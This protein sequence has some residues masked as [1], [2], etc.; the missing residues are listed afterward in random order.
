MRTR[1]KISWSSLATAPSPTT[2]PIIIEQLLTS[3]RRGHRKQSSKEANGRGFT[4]PSLRLQPTQ[5][6]LSKRKTPLVKAQRMHLFLWTILRIWSH[7][8]QELAAKTKAKKF[9]PPGVYVLQADLLG[10]NE[11]SLAAYLGLPDTR[12]LRELVEP[13][14]NDRL[15]RTHLQARENGFGVKGKNAATS[16]PTSDIFDCL[17]MDEDDWV[18]L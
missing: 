18:M 1:E 12:T 13:P 7:V 3:G 15:L 9:N 16:Y 2:E 17:R 5:C 14:E 6:R 8:Q 4:Y 11:R 10:N